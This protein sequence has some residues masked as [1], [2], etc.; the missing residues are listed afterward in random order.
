MLPSS[1]EIVF[2]A[3]IS[4]IA[5]GEG[6]SLHVIDNNCALHKIDLEQ[7][8]I[9]KSTTLSSSFTP[10]LFDYY[11]RPFALGKT[12]AYISFS[13]EGNEY[14][15]DTKSKLAK[16]CSFNH[17]AGARVTK[18]RLSD[19]D[20]LLITGNEKGRTFV[21]NTNDGNLIAELPRS[22]DTI[23]AVTLNDT[24]KIAARAS[25]SR[26]LVVYRYT[27]LS[28]VLELRLDAVIEMLTCVDETTLLAITRNGKIL[29][30]DT[31]KGRVVQETLLDENLW[32]SFMSLSNSKKFVYVGTR[33]SMLFAL[34]VNSL[35]ILF[36][37][38]LPYLGITSFVRTGRYFIFSFKSGE[39]LF[40]NHREFEDPFTLNIKLKKIKEASLYFHKNIFLMTHRDTRLIYDEWVVQKETIINLLSLGHID[41]AKKLVDPFLFHPKCKLEF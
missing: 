6:S 15:I 22:S 32:P 38:K 37:V 14:I 21:I 7:L 11:Y 30:I 33:E 34:H 39:I 9:T 36:H 4:R 13:K 1:R 3:P 2:H 12:R 28:V 40:L 27:S 18:A 25:F 29:K 35:D 10:T 17:N 23:T 24:Y 8:R 20:K 41:E 5:L 31:D 19:N 16:I 26:T